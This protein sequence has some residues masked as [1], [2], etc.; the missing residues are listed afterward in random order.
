MKKTSFP[1]NEL[2]LRA[3]NGSKSEIKADGIRSNRPP[4]FK[5]ESRKLPSSHTHT[6]HIEIAHQEYI[7]VRQSIE[8]AKE[9][10]LSR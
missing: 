5:P 9:N 7:S 4:R 1:L 2:F 10:P 3:F 6:Q 8:I